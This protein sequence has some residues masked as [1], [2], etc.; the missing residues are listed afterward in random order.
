[1]H[2]SRPLSRPRI[3]PVGV[4]LAAAILAVTSQLGANVLGGPPGGADP[5][6]GAAAI[7]PAGLEPAGLPGTDAAA[8]AGL[9]RG[10]GPWTANLERSPRDFFAATSL[11][12]LFGARGRLTGDVADYVRGR[13]A[14]DAALGEVPDY[15]PARLTA[16]TL[17]HALHDFE[18]ARATA[19]AL[20]VERPGEPA[21]LAVAADALLELGRLAEAGERYD[22]LADVAAG[23]A[24]DIRLARLALVTGREAD[25]RALADAARD[26]AVADPASH[27]VAFYHAAAAEIARQTGDAARARAGFEA[28]IAARP[29][30]IVAAIGLARLDAWAGETGAAIARLEAVV[31]RLPQPEAVGLLAD[32]RAAG[33]DERGEATAVATLDAFRELAGAGEGAYDRILVRFDL[34]HGRATGSTLAAAKADLAVR[35]DAGGHDLV[36]WALHRLGRSAEAGGHVDAALATGA[37]DARLLFHAG[38]IDV[39]TGARERGRERLAAA[40]ELGPA[41]D[42]VERDEALA[43]LDAVRPSGD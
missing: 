5:A 10:I 3:R 35:S 32:L 36:A 33:G 43:L 30:S 40:L 2:S 19:E 9:D 37:A 24:V 21:A 12:T 34:D 31:A 1:M 15:A 18:A 38:A 13:A 27:D 4:V 25:A 41:L 17:D 16:A 39:A 29:A 23:P 42:P 14:A 22:D 11:A 7:E 20:L 8:L 6:P 26:G 28:A